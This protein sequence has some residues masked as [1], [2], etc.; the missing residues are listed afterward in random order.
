M[1]LVALHD[2]GL[3]PALCCTTN[4]IGEMDGHSW[5]YRRTTQWSTS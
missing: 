1:D 2:A 4:Y 5:F 3:E